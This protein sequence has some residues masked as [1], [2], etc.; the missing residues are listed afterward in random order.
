MN[1]CPKHKEAVTL[2]AAGELDS[3]ESLRVEA[4]LT[5]CA[6]CRAYTDE[7]RQLCQLVG[8]PIA[9]IAR[10][11]LPARFHEKL[12]ARITS[13]SDETPPAPAWAELRAW[14]TFPRLA[15]TAGI[16]VTLAT[17]FLVSHSRPGTTPSIASGTN[18]T[19]VPLTA[20]FLRDAELAANSTL[21]AY[22]TALSR[23]FE[24]FDALAVDN[25]QRMLASESAAT[26]VMSTAAP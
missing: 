17:I 9:R 19:P 16:T 24:D 1:P 8:E 3:G 12:A 18:A 26:R 22:R 21:L 7:L 13:A 5:K 6:A 14:L 11:D 15:L 4:H 25:A 20:P 23:S 2:F 10:A